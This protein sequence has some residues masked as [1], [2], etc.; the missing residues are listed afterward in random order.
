MSSVRTKLLAGVAAAMLGTTA[1][2]ADLPPPTL[3]QPVPVSFGG[4]YLRGD[5]GMSNQRLKNLDYWRFAGAPGFTWLDKGGFDSAPF[6]G[7]GIGYQYNDWLRFDLTGEYRGKSNFH[8]LDRYTD[9]GNPSGFGS[10]NYT[11]TKREWVFLANAYVDLGTWWCITPFIGAGVGFANITIDHFTDT[12][13]LSAGGGY[14]GS[15]STTN[16]AWALHAGL[17]YKAS[18]NVTF[19]IAYRYLN[20]GDGQTGIAFN[21]DG[22]TSNSVFTFKDITSHDLKFGVRWALDAGLVGK[23]PVFAAPPPVYKSYQQTITVPQQP[24]YQEQPPLMRRG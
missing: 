19:E 16:F 5:I 14:A 21:L 22:S 13:V 24:V 10:D 7:L 18:P 23:Q 11:G 12:N 2:A 3:Y 9:S 1:Y 8:A 15:G 20:L 6:V 17:A 4:W